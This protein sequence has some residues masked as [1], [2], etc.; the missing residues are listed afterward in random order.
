MRIAIVAHHVPLPEG[1]AAGRSLHALVGGLRSLDHEVT[2]RAWAPDAP[3][4][5]PPSWCDWSPLRG[6]DV[7]S[8]RWTSLRRPRGEAIAVGDIPDADL[9]VADDFLSFPAIENRPRTG[10][11]FHYASALDVAVTRR[12]GRTLQD[13]RAERS[14]ARAAHA[15][16]AYSP[17]VAAAIRAGARRAV[18]SVPLAVAVPPA[19]RKP[20]EEPV[21]VLLGDWRWPPNQAAARRL[22]SRWPAVR[23]AVPAARL[24]LAGR[25]EM[26]LAGPGVEV[27]GPV[28]TSAEVLA[29]ASVLCFPCPRSSGPKVKV[30]EALGYGVPVVTTAWG[31]EGA[32][33]TA[34]IVTAAGPAFEREVASL[35]SDPARAAAIGA[36]GRR[37]VLRVH[38]PDAAAS[39]WLRRFQESL[40]AQP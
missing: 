25:G 40:S 9:F 21:A 14:A 11:S 23:A 1:T 36:E 3:G 30:L 38:G 8:S 32:V 28:A 24:I 7:R 16:L 18:A 17:R 39:A 12:P 34:G 20:V 15:A 33:H 5:D 4:G 2:V 29:E 27:R 31:A 35:L 37:D 6:A 13:I 26:N 22:V 19:A 10:V